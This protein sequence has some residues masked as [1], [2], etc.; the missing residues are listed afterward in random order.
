MT[1][2]IANYYD[3][4]RIIT[5]LQYVYDMYRA[6]QFMYNVPTY[7]EIRLHRVSRTDQRRKP[8]TPCSL[9]CQIG[10]KFELSNLEVVTTDLNL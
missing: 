10:V 5:K 3:C 4:E 1:W 9:V 6:M 2:T 8:R 7:T